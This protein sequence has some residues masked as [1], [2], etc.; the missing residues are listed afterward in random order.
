MGIQ[1]VISANT[2]Q[3]DRLHISGASLLTISTQQHAAIAHQ[4]EQL[5]KELRILVLGR[6][7]TKL[8]TRLEPGS[9]CVAECLDHLTQTTRAFLP[10]IS[11]AVARAPK[12]ATNRRLRTGILP[13]LFI[14][15]LNPPYHIRF[16]VLPRLAP[17]NPDSDT[18]WASFLQSQS[19]LAA[20]L[21]S[22]AG[23]A[24]DKVRIKAPVYARISYNIYGAF[25]MLAAHQSR[26]VWQI[27]QILRVLDSRLTTVA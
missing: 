9:W 3:S 26:H 8:M 6:T 24:I 19:E 21:N 2:E 22:A 4:I 13:S 27:S 23:L 1:A 12:L 7:K 18:A 16:K 14:R 20:V 11:E 25:R 10:A 17:Q 5:T 15:N